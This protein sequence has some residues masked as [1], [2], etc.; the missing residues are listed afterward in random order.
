MKTITYNPATHKLVPIEPDETMGSKSGMHVA[1]TCGRR[2][3]Q[4]A[5]NKYGDMLAAA[6]EV[7]TGAQEGERA[8][9]VDAAKYRA[10]NTPEIDDFV[11]AVQAEA[12]HQRDRWAAT[13]DAGKADAD[14]FWLIGYLAGKAIAKNVTPEKQLHHIITTAA[15]CLNWHGARVGAYTDMRPGIAPPIAA[16]TKPTSEGGA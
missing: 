1:C 6:P 16:S 7:E 4:W 9:A 14:W 15:A 13:G 2:I 8:D 5:I 12:L 10:L 11:A 3:T